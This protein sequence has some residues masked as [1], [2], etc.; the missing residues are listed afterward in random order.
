MWAEHRLKSEPSKACS[1]PTCRGKMERDPHTLIR[2]L[3]EEL[4]MHQ[5]REMVHRVGCG[6]CGRKSVV[7]KVYKCLDCAS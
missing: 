1:C 6:G 2:H 3:G 5:K 4:H 7:G